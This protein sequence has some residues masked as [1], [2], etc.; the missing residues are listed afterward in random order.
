MPVGQEVIATIRFGCPRP[1]PA[2]GAGRSSRHRLGARLPAERWAAPV[3]PRAHPV[4]D[5][6]AQQPRRVPDRLAG[7]GAVDSLALEAALFVRLVGGQDHDIGVADLDC[8]QRVG[9]PGR[10]PALHPDVIAQH[11]GGR[12]QRLG[13]HGGVGGGDLRIPSL[14]RLFSWLLL[15][16]GGRDGFSG[17]GPGP[18]SRPSIFPRYPA[19]ADAGPTVV[20]VPSEKA[21]ASRAQPSR[22]RPRSLPRTKPATIASPAP[23]VLRTTTAGGRTHTAPFLPRR[24]RRPAPWKP[25]RSRCPGRSGPA[26]PQGWRLRRE[27]RA[28]SVPPVPPGSA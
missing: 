6:V 4:A 16:D 7:G 5:G 20:S 1:A 15:P 22:S 23:T 13:R 14:R 24:S 27:A 11:V 2:S 3:R 28:P 21:V 25:R 17:Q 9:C 19:A 18:R 10:T 8:G 12:F 26:R